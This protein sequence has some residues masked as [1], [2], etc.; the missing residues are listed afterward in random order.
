MLQRD[1]T[2]QDRRFESWMTDVSRRVN[3]LH[4]RPS[5]SVD[6]NGEIRLGDAILRFDTQ[7]DGSV[8]VT[9]RNATTGGSPVKLAYLE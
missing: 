5:A 1:V 2:P 9:M 4:R 8:E 6:E 7:A 3:E